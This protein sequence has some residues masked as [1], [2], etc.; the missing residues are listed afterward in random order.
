M[1]FFIRKLGNMTNQMDLA[2]NL[3][4]KA[5]SDV[6][7]LTAAP[8]VLSGTGIIIPAFSLSSSYVCR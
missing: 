5:A 4:M 6:P 8:P 1:P 7:Y 2:F 3:L